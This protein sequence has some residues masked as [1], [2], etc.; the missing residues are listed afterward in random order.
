MK[1]ILGNEKG[2]GDH[3]FQD[4]FPR[5]TRCGA[6]G[7]KADLAFVAH[8]QDEPIAAKGGKYVCQIHK[9]SS[10]PGGLWL[11]DA[12]CVA[13][14]FCRHCLEATAKLNQA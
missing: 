10:K 7:E 8:E 4:P 11:H 6:C 5:S 14:Y 3:S 13:V 12:C 2:V 9:T 1:T